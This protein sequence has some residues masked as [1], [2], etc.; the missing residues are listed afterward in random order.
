M[1]RLN[2]PLAIAA[3]VLVVLLL[4]VFVRSRMT[5]TRNMRN[6]FEMQDMLRRGASADEMEEFLKANKIDPNTARR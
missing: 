1:K 2:K 5:E 4:A 6:Y 3:V